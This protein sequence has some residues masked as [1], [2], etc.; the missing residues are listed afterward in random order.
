MKVKV[1]TA[2][3]DLD[4]VDLLD[5]KNK[6]LTC[7][8]VLVSILLAMHEED[9]NMTGED[10]ILRYELAKKINGAGECDMIASEITLC[11]ELMG[12]YCVPLALGQMVS[13][14]EPKKVV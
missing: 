6:P 7:G 13:I 4:G 12:K 10:K 2:L 14:I 1:G 11:Q 8:K 5:D 3:T 9:K